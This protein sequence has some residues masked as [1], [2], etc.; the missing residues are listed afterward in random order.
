M[1]GGAWTVVHQRGAV[2]EVVS[3]EEHLSVTFGICC[4]PL[5]PGEQL[6]RQAP[7]GLQLLCQRLHGHTELLEA[8]PRVDNGRR[9]RDV[10]VEEAFLGTSESRLRPL[11]AVTR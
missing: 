9:R 3:V 6:L 10:A 11:S 4:T 5:D 2:L 7:L 8:E 1:R